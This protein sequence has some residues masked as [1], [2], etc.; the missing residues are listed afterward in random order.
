MQTLESLADMIPGR[1]FANKAH[2]ALQR[3]KL[4]VDV[5]TAVLILGCFTVLGVTSA[6]AEARALMQ[7]GS[8]ALPEAPAAEYD[9]AAALEQSALDGLIACPQV[10]TTVLLLGCPISL[11]RISLQ[12]SRGSDKALLADQVAGLAAELN[13]NGL[14]VGR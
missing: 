6:G 3:L 13:A 8:Q 12:F 5:Q 14:P 4:R 10:L 1:H 7:E 11:D 9:G 2:M